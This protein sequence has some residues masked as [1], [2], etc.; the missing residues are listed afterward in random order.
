MAAN[1]KVYDKTIEWVLAKQREHLNE[2]IFED[3]LQTNE[4]RQLLTEVA[5]CVIQSGNEIAKVNA[6]E[7]RLSKDPNNNLKE[8]FDKIRGT[9]TNERL[10]IL[11]NTSLSLSSIDRTHALFVDS[12]INRS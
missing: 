10:I 8:L 6:I 1:V 9:A 11:T 7:Y 3:K 2:K 12:L 5:V 4:L